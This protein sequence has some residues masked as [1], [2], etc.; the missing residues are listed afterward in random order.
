MKLKFLII[1]FVLALTYACEEELNPNA[2]FLER[3]ILT[4]VLRSDT[5]FQ[6][7]T[8]SKSYEVNGIDPVSNQ[9]DHFI[10]GADVKVWYK[11]NVYQ[12]IEDTLDR[13]DKS[14]YNFPVKI[15]YN[16]NLKISENS[17]VEIEAL[18]PQ[19]FLLRSSTT[20]PHL[21]I[22]KFDNSSKFIH[23]DSLTNDV[24]QFR[25][26]RFENTYYH[27]VFVIRY[28]DKT[29][30]NSVLLEKV[31][32]L[33][34]NDDGSQKFTRPTNAQAVS[35]TLPNF[36]K[37]LNEI[38]TQGSGRKDDYSIIRGELK[39]MVYD[40][41]LSAYYSSVGTFLDGFTIK[42]DQPDF[43]NVDGGFGIFGS[44]AIKRYTVITDRDYLLSLGFG[45]R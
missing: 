4:S 1:I 19:G 36:V 9:E 2:E 26:T 30:G 25:W 23:P 18:L 22:L 45:E 6:V 20:V 11:D 16:E 3:N 10:T 38:V 44:F 40:K 27:P 32:P 41:N 28:Y 29:V 39:I 15:Y 8:L 21:S 43:S 31:V 34:Y 5:S 17:E 42:V 35:Y 33:Q 14:R 37:A 13:I 7:I 24:I 12:F